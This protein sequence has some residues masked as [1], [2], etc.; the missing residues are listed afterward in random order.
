M[1][2]GMCPLCPEGTKAGAFIQA[3]AEGWTFSYLKCRGCGMVFLSPRPDDQEMLPFYTQEYYGGGDHKFH[4]GIEVFR[5]FFARKRVRRVQAFLSAPGNALDIGCGQGT[6]LQLLREEGWDC[7]GTELTEESA[8]RASLRGIP[9]SVGEFDPARF[10]SHSFD[11]ITLWHVLEHLRDPRKTL[12]S[13]PGLLKP[14]GLVAISTP[15]VDSLQAEV[16]KGKWFHL[17]APR[18]L[19]L[20]S[21]KTLGR[22]MESLGF[23][24]VELNHF[25][26]EQ[27]PYGWLQS[28][29]NL[30]GLPENSLYGTLKNSPESSPKYFS[31]LQ[32]AKAILLTGSLLPYSI[33]LS[34]LMALLHRGGTIEAYFQA[35]TV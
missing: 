7:Q 18:H 1:E 35:R 21:P 32:K 30:A 5:S 13:L 23:R 24:L 31:P 19:Y 14:G 20:F 16:G 25:S 12:G 29:L 15:N 9:V 8:R 28:L 11:L 10:P 34:V 3:H 4:P 6:F 17:D 2:K 33:F 26:M 22:V 27:N